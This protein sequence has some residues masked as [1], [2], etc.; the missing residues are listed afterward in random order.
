MTECLAAKVLRDLATGVD[1]FQFSL[2]TVG[3]LERLKGDL[4]DQ[5]VPGEEP[6]SCRRHN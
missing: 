1:S 4:S 5:T 2:H 6:A 3:E